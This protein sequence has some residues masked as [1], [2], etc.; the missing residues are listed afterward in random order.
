ME[1]FCRERYSPTSTMPRVRQQLWQGQLICSLSVLFYWTLIK[2]GFSNIKYFRIER[3]NHYHHIQFSCIEQ[4][5][6][7]IW[8]FRCEISAL[9]W[10][11]SLRKSN[12]STD[13]LISSPERDFVIVSFKLTTS[14]SRFLIE[15]CSETIS[16]VSVAPICFWSFFHSKPFQF[17][18]W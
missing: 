14:L 12:I 10:A 15:V 3:L 17:C 2:S 11:I 16:T 9:F 13:C 5:S 1:S 7:D 8:H 4:L 18:L 6:T